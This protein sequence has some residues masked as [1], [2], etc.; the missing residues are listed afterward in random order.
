M[1]RKSLKHSTIVESTN[2][3]TGETTTTETQKTFSIQTTSESFYLTFLSFIQEYIGLNDAEKKV[4]AII[5]TE[6]DFNKNSF[7]MNKSRREY[8][9][10]TCN[11]AYQTLANTMT[12]LKKKC[13]IEVLNGEVIVNPKF[14]WKGD[15]KVRERVLKDKGLTLNVNFLSQGE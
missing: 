10:D 11:M 15:L 4:L 1:G 5:C 3:A 9:C 2:H 6:M 13:V 7:S 12:N 14:L 8:L